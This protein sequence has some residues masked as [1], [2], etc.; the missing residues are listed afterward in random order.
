MSRHWSVSILRLLALTAFVG[1]ASTRLLA[2][3]GGHC[4]EGRALFVRKA[5]AA[6]QAELWQCVAA[7]AP[8]R[9]SAWLL[10]QTYREL[11]DYRE[12]FARLGRLPGSEASVDRIYIEGFLLFRTGKHRESIEVLGSGFRLDPRDW[13]LHHVF[14]LNYVV[15]E[16]VEG[17]LHELQVAIQL[18]PRNAEL[19]Y[20]LAR[21]LYS[22]SRVAESIEA[23]EK[24]ISLEPD[25]ADVYTNL[26]LC[27][28]ALAEDAKAR[29]NYEKAIEINRRLRRTDEWPFLNYASYLIKQEAPG[30]SLS[31]LAEALQ[32]NPRS[33]RGYYLRGKALNKL[34]RLPEAKLDLERS[35]ALDPRDASPYYEL[36][37]LLRRLGDAAGSKRIFE[38]FQALSKKPAPELR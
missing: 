21:L 19:H 3:A 30:R 2:Q 4:E 15:L 16:I 1:P 6:A 12:G 34:E 33:G 38:N 10:A 9:E 11:K 27:H 32:Q 13:R 24:A 5:F 20:Q 37:V 7:G 35:I 28:E 29:L 31:L 14:A 17:A 25:Y 23:S 8:S 22:Q 18:N 36:G 26:G